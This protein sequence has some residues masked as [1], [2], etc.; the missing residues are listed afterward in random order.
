MLLGE[1]IKDATK[2]IMKEQHNVKVSLKKINSISIEHV[3]KNKIIL[4][5]FLLIF[6]TATIKTK[7]KIILTNL[8][9]NK[10]QIISSDYKLIK[11]NLHKKTEINTIISN[12]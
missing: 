10:S 3:K 4:H 7:E 5:S 12:L 11:E 2:R 1:S 6:V 8:Q 9:K